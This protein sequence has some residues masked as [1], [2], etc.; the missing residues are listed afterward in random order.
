MEKIII[1][2]REESLGDLIKRK[3][4]KKKRPTFAWVTS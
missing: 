4:Q 1:R 2:R 3:W